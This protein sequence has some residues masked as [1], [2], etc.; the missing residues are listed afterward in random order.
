MKHVFQ[1]GRCCITHMLT[2]K[3]AVYAELTVTQTKPGHFFCI[4]G[5]G[6]ELHD[7]R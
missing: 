7:L 3:G 6:S 4:T 1:V 2:P 5:S